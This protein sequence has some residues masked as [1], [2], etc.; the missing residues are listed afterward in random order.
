[1]DGLRALV[2]Q[3]SGAERV[4]GR[5]VVT[6]ACTLALHD[7][8]HWP[9]WCTDAVLARYPEVQISVRA[10][11]T[12]LSGFTVVF[13]RRRS[14]ARELLWHLVIGLALAGCAYVIMRWSRGIARI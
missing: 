10:S 9:A 7:C 4:G 8:M 2:L 1:M 6:D 13:H 11:R 12:S 5:A 14:G 3:L